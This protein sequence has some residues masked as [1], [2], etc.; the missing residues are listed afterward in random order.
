[1]DTY[2]PFADAVG[3]KEEFVRH[4]WGILNCTAGILGGVFAGVISDRIFQSRRGPVSAVL[5]GVM[6]VG[7][8]VAIGTLVVPGFAG[9][10]WVLMLLAIIGVHGMLSGTASMDFGGKKNTGV[11]VGLIDGFVYFGGALGQ[12]VLKH[13][14]PADKSAAA[15]DPK[16]WWTWPATL[17]PVAIVGF[18][19]TTRLWNAKPASKAA[20]SH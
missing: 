17:L 11:A 20:S 4:N 6:V 2:K 18:L 14:I 13:T 10:P 15:G 19:L 5:Y 7:T 8:G 1:M 9:W 16:N 3:R 12:Y